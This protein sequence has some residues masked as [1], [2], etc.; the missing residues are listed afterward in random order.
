[1]G[2]QMGNVNANEMYTLA[3]AFETPPLQITLANGE[4]YELN[5]KKDITILE[6]AGLVMLFSAMAYPN[7]LHTIVERY[8]LQR[9]FDLVEKQSE[10]KEK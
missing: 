10:P 6:G 1:M 3:R 2:T 8:S 7:T 9:H 4:I 5:P